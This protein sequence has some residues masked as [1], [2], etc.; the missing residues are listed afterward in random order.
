MEW[1]VAGKDAG[2]LEGKQNNLR[3]LN[4]Q[5]RIQIKDQK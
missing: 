4:F 3:P 2:Q 1:A 5:H